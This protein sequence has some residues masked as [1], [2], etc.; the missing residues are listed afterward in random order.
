MVAARSREHASATL[1]TLVLR[2]MG[3]AT[4]PSPVVAMDRVSA[5]WHHTAPTVRSVHV[6]LTISELLAVLSAAPLR[7]AQA[8]ANVPQLVSAS[9]RQGTPA[10]P[11]TR[12]QRGTTWLREHVISASQGSTKPLTSTPELSAPH[13]R[14]GR[15]TLPLET[16]AHLTWQRWQPQPPQVR[17]LWTLVTSQRTSLSQLGRPSVIYLCRYWFYAFFW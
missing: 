16:V 4:P 14:Q 12:V 13:A 3:S 1:I 5:V 2:A 8:T 17:Y 15:T 10:R 9:A 11:A 6:Q 7:R